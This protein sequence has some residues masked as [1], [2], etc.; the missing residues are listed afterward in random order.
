MR[1]AEISS[2]LVNYLIELPFWSRYLKKTFSSQ[3]ERLMKPFDERLQTVFD[4]GQTLTD[5]DYRERMNLISLDRSRAE[6]AEIKRR[7]ED[8]LKPGA[9]NVCEVPLL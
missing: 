1:T 4:Q 7:T 3:F 6:T 5:G 8:A 2:A 9:L